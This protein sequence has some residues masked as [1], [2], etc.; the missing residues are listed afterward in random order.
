RRTK[1]VLPI[2]LSL[3]TAGVLITSGLFGVAAKM[4]LDVN[5]NEALLLGAIVGSTDAAAVFAVL[6]GKNIKRKLQS[7][8]EAESGSNDPMAMFLTLT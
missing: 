6:K 1:A 3:A 2:S 4:I 8:L 5:W 7:S